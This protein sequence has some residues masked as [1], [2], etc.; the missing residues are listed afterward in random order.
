M[1]KS[2]RDDDDEISRVQKINEGLQTLRKTVAVAA[3][4]GSRKRAVV[5][6][7]RKRE[8][9]RSRRRN[10]RKGLCTTTVSRPFMVNCL[11]LFGVGPLKGG[12]A[13]VPASPGCLFA[14]RCNQLVSESTCFFSNVE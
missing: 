5:V 8:R 6:G 2:D 13:G 12:R 4:G 1:G 3:A 11:L 14:S 9:K 10:P 7:R